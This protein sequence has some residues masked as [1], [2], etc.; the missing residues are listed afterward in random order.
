M[1]EKK[2]SLGKGIKKT[3]INFGLNALTIFAA[4]LGNAVP[5]SAKGIAAAGLA[6]VQGVIN[7]IKNK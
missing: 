3:L 2:Y 7:Y 1:E 5:S 4:D 6:L